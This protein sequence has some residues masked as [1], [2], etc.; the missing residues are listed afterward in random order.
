MSENASPTLREKGS[1]DYGV[2]LGERK[3]TVRARVSGK[4][5]FP[6]PLRGRVAGVP[7]VRVLER[8]EKRVE[9]GFDRVE[10]RLDRVDSK[11]DR[12]RETQA[13]TGERVARL[14]AGHRWPG[15]RS[16]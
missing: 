12:L 2:R 1:D 7:L 16:S 8:F 5:P 3:G 11:I 9:A 10:V 14:E 13:R 6:P 15:E 4:P